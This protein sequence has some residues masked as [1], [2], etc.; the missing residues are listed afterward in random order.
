MKFQ[1]KDSGIGMTAGQLLR[2]FEAFA[3]ADSS[4][5]RKYGGT[6][7]GLAITKKFCEM[8]DGTIQVESEFGKGNH[9]HGAAPEASCQRTGT[10]SA[11]PSTRSIARRRLLASPAA[12]AAIHRTCPGD[13]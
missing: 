12:I 11:G 13:R 1:V 3:Q 9:L 7:L 6:G 10:M 4:T 5:T 8:M 2:V